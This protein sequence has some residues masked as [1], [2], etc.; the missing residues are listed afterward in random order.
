[1][2]IGL[3]ANRR[4][5]N[6]LFLL[7]LPLLAL[8]FLPSTSAHSAERLVRVGVYD[9]PPKIYRDS[10]LRP[11]GFF[12]ELIDE[13]GK[14]EKWKINYE[15]C[16][17]AECLQ[18][19]DAGEIDLMP[20]VAI[21]DERAKYF[22]FHA[23]PVVN[24]WSTILYHPRFSVLG[25]KDLMGRRI[26]VLRGG[27]Q[28][29][30]LSKM[31]SSSEI[32]YQSIY[33]DSLAQGFEAVQAGSADA[34]V[35][36]NLFSGRNAA[37]YGLRLSPIVF[38]PASLQFA[39]TKGRNRDLLLAI[40]RHLE[41]WRDDA[42][43]V[44]YRAL[45]RASAAPPVE[46]VGIRIK[47]IL[48]W[49][50]PLLLLLLASV[51]LALYSNRRLEHLVARRTLELQ[52]EIETRKQAE[53]DLQT[54]RDNLE[55][56]VDTRTAELDKAKLAA[57]AANLAKSGFLAN[58]SHEL[59]TP[60]N[61]ILGFSQLLSKDATATQAQ[62]EQLEIINR[63]GEHLLLMI[64][65]VLDL[66]KIEAG[67]M[68]LTDAVF[69]LHILC[70]EIA[71]LMR[72]RASEKGL[73]LNLQIDD[74]VPRHIRSD[75]TKLR[76][77]VLNLL[78][79]AVKFTL[80]GGILL[81]V[82]CPRDQVLRIEV[83]DTGPGIKASAQ[84]AIFNPFV[85]AENLASMRG[86]GL[87]LTISRKI[88]EMMDGQI[89]LSSALGEGSSFWLEIPLQRP[90]ENEIVMETDEYRTVVGLQAEQ[91]PWRILVAEDD[92]DSQL[93]IR[94]ALLQIGFEVKIA[95]DGQ[96][97]VHLFREWHP[98]LILM[99][100]R[101][102]LLDG[103]QATRTIRSLPEG[104]A[105]PIVALT[106][107]VFSEDQPQILASGCNE[108]LYKPINIAR[109]LAGIARHL[110]VLYCYEEIEAFVAE[111]DSPSQRER[112]SAEIAALPEALRQAMLMAAQRLDAEAIEALL[113]HLEAHGSG[114]AEHVAACLR[115]FDFG[116]IA[117]EV[118]SG[119]DV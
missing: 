112:F 48:T 94:Q 32:S 119:L 102:P 61:A 47:T 28:E 87:G 110:P 45:A 30:A 12:I 109:L 69:D 51:A 58:M 37:K 75:V 20:D 46:I 90:T 98:H 60:L 6:L 33:V 79:N 52:G 108:V 63:S 22:D 10:N 72:Q 80:K 68:S 17:W 115:Q 105:L 114:L 38:S 99:D 62:R 64:N 8:V 91:V 18:K 41:A 35:A 59:R 111:D 103:M 86:T 43:S 117:E 16:I 3:M 88:V 26:A 84:K 42:D 44:F 40:D 83:K 70:V 76:Q 107:S 95:A 25:L 100:I 56:L 15:Y 67:K 96:E 5:T 77:V 73:W 65:D 36:N 85:Q 31:M 13:I 57:E 54:H 55:L 101:M 11:Q 78:G 53:A 19:L 39:T 24:S 1:M 93:F 89:G 66:S 81:R 9:N 106:A 4:L 7:F 113:P 14:L 71:G 29:T 118:G 2:S 49:G 74:E 92:H 82:G 34:V 50:G 27:V 104:A 116:R 97:A 23:T 21:S